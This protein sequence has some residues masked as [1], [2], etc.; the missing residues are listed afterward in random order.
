MTIYYQ[1]KRVTLHH[2]DC[3]EVMRSMPESSVDAVVTDP[4]Y[5]IGF[6]GKAWDATFIS[7]TIAK[8]RSYP[9]AGAWRGGGGVSIQTWTCATCTDSGR[10]GYC[11]PL[12]CYC[13]HETCHAFAS[14]T[15]LPVSNV[16]PIAKATAAHADSWANREE[17]TWIDKM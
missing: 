11:A 4:P 17:S 7:D 14:W 12:R 6:M 2:G 10:K 1:D 8:R 15:P 16:T 9:G 5:G 13:G 3:I